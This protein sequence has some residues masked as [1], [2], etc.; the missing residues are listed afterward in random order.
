MPLRRR[1]GDVGRRFVSALGI[2]VS[3]VSSNSAAACLASERNGYHVL[4]FD[5]YG[6]G[7]S[8][9]RRDEGDL[10]SWCADASVAVDEL[11]DMSGCPAV[12]RVAFV[13]EPI[14]GW[15]LALTRYDVAAVMMWDPVVRGVHYVR[16]LVEN[17]IGV[18]SDRS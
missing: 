7:D 11:R 8:A 2:G 16:E 15:R 5:Y 4:R 14:I 1:V 6:H 9:G 10:E 18:T 12:V 17:A 3:G 13:S